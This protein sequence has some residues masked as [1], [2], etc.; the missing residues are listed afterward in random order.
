MPFVK[1]KSGNPA[2][3]PK[4]SRNKLADQ[5]FKD[6]L[7]AWESRGADALKAI[8]PD[9]L[10]KV[11]AG[12]MPKEI[13]QTVRTMSAQQMSDDELADIAAGSS[14]DTADSPDAAQVTH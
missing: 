13:D 10:V 11:A 1:G 9:V 3:R 12:V 4:G 8:E 7:A 6:M 5:F 2:G 14:E